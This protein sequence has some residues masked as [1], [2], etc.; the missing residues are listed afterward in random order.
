[1]F[2]PH[3]K[4]TGRDYTMTVALL[5]IAL[6][7]VPT[8]FVALRPGGH[9]LVLAFASSAICVFFS[10]LSWARNSQL[11]IPSIAELPRTL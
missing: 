6:I 10:L 7:F 5:A 2:D 3:L 8:A 9:S 1:M 4:S 11:T